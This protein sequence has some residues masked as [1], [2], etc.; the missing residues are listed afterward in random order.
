MNK[1][2]NLIILL[3]LACMVSCGNKNKSTYNGKTMM[4]IRLAVDT[5]IKVNLDAVIGDTAIAVSNVEN[6]RRDTFSI[7]DAKFSNKIYGELKVGDVF[8]IMPLFEQHSI[9]SA[10][11]LNE[12]SGLWLCSDG[13]GLNF[14]A[15]DVCSPV[16]VLDETVSLRHW[17]VQNGRL[18][19]TYVMADGS[20]YTERVDTTDIS[21]L[22]DDNLQI[23][24]NGKTFN[25]KHFKG[26]MTKDNMPK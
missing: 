13:T 14:M 18:L 24:I 20:D 22:T 11:N 26:L 12:M 4:D 25:C 3:A 23:T 5:T 9:R 6:G 15:D 10:Y 17:V 2:L 16:G 7:K 21:N 1:Y 19:I 8:A